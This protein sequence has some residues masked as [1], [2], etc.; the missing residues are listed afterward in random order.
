MGVL[1]RWIDKTSRKIDRHTKPSMFYF[2]Q[3]LYE[4]NLGPILESDIKQNVV[5]VIAVT[6]A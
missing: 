3:I 4:L 1:S 6:E 2:L 5:S